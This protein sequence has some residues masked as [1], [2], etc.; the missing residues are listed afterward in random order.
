MLCILFSSSTTSILAISIY[1]LFFVGFILVYINLFIFQLFF[2]SILIVFFI[3][4]FR[5]FLMELIS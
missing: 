5:L 4:F 1:H 2:Y 3:V